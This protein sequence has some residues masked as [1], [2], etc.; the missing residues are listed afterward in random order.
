MSNG[1]F[2]VRC[3]WGVSPGE[4]FTT[5]KVYEVRN[6]GITLDNE[7]YN[8]GY[9]IEGIEDLSS[10]YA[11][12]FEMV[13]D[14][15]TT[16]IY[17]AGNKTIATLKDGNKTI[18]TAKATCNPKDTFNAEFGRE[19][20]LARLNGNQ[21]LVEWLLKEDK[22]LT[23]DWIS[24][25]ERFSFTPTQSKIVKQDKY[26]VGDKVKLVS[27]RP[28]TWNNEGEMDK[29][30]G[31]EVVITK[32]IGN[33]FFE[34]EGCEGWCF[35][36][37]K[38][39]EGKVIRESVDT[40]PFDW[41]GFKS[42]KFAVH[43]DTDEK[44]KG[45][46]AE[47]ETQGIKWRNGDSLLSETDWDI[48]KNQTIYE[49]TCGSFG[50]CQIN[51]ITHQMNKF[52]IINY[53]PSKP[54]LK[55]VTRKAKVGEWIKVVGNG[56]KVPERYKNGG[57]YKT[58]NEK[59]SC[60]NGKGICVDGGCFVILHEDYVV[61]ESY[62]PEED[63]PSSEP[64]Q[65]AKVGDRIKIV[66]DDI[67]HGPEV[68]NGDIQTV[69]SVGTD[70]VST[71]EKNAFHDADQEYIIIGE[72][73]RKAK[74]GDKIKVIKGKYTGEILTVLN[75]CPDCINVKCHDYFW[76]KDQE[77]IIVEEAKVESIPTETP[78]NIGDTVKIIDKGRTCNMYR[79]FIEIYAKDFI[80]KFE[81]RY[82]PKNGDTGVVVGKG[83]HD[84]G[85][86]SYVVLANDKA[87]C[88]REKGIEKV[89]N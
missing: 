62:Q 59:G 68:K 14:S 9:H 22:G 11:S 84:F 76:D 7:E 49:M 16:I 2:K 10:H 26:E 35:S 45:F 73:F 34:F 79:E 80:A 13:D 23:A 15:T 24:T 37:R 39:V 63:K 25:A 71:K 66:K 32:A 30:L 69:D 64:F 28:D 67:V 21:K 6:Y 61:L 40:T 31:K 52:D 87:F 48:F 18:K 70:Y 82:L 3:T 19:L 4:Y 36:F 12:R 81:S 20:A 77:Y 86:M 33:T 17:R 56:E 41:E 72:S 51:G 47:C 44:A 78:I 55:E 60:C 83:L 75:V 50:Y 57:I 29:Y 89:R 1:N 58:T 53:T 5:G 8:D 38:S 85:G 88:I 27:V 46:L 54:T 74:V 43:C 65:K 42:G